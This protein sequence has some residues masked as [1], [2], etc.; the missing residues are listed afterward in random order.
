MSYRIPRVAALLACLMT[1]NVHADYFSPRGPELET[2][3]VVYVYRPAASNPGK[4]PLRTKY[5]EIMVDGEG[6]GFL[7][8]NRHFRLELP[9]G[10][11]EFVATGLTESANWKQTDR[12][13]IL[14]MKAGQT[15]YLR[16]RVEYDT[17]KMSIGTFRGQYLIFL[18]AMDPEE[19]IYQ[20]RETRDDLE[21]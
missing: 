11:H 6:S 14:N 4:K 21:S 15:Y 7:K 5:P 12:K 2:N 19:A 9:A 20:I 13:Y 16:L 17:D 1:T 3:A 10:K 18:H 8:Y